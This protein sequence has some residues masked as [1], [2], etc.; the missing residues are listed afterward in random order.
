[1]PNIYIFNKLI[2][3]LKMQLLSNLNLIKENLSHQK[4]NTSCPA[5]GIVGFRNFI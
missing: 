5:D 4:N 2:H 3:I 1:M